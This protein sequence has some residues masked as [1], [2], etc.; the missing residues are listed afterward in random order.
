MSLSTEFSYDNIST[1]ATTTIKTGHG[2]LH[3]VM[4]NSRGS[5]STITVYDNTSG[6]G[7][8]IATIDSTASIG[9]L[10][11]DIAFSIGLTVVTSGLTPSDITVSYR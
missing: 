7:T 8:K 1:N 5:S 2:I 10:I 6:S 9:Q 3:S 4:I 11:Y